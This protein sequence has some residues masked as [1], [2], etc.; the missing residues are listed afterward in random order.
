MR[1]VIREQGLQ[2][3]TDLFI[4]EP[5]PL[6]MPPHYSRFWAA[7]YTDHYLSDQGIMLDHNR[8]TDAFSTYGYRAASFQLQQAEEVRGPSEIQIPAET[9][10]IVPIAGTSHL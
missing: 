6:T 4:G 8:H 2:F 10:A 1:A 5:L 3:S 7:S 9:T